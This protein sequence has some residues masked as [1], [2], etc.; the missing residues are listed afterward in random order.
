[1]TK[2]YTTAATE[3]LESLHDF[4]YRKPRKSTRLPR[5]GLIEAAS[6]IRVRSACSGSCQSFRHA[7]KRGGMGIDQERDH[8]ESLHD[9]RYRKPRKSTRLP[10]RKTT[11]VYTP[12][13]TENLESLHD[14]RYGKP[15]KSTRLPLRAR[16]RTTEHQRPERPHSTDRRQNSPWPLACPPSPKTHLLQSSCDSNSHT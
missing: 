7:R 5:P 15:R 1:M 3:N 10:L 8:D 16:A 14:C 13:A 6:W 4:R 2:V 11:K 9:F 12:A